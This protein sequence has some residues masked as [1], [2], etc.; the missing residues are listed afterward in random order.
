MIDGAEERIRCGMSETFKKVPTVLKGV[1]QVYPNVS[2]DTPIYAN[3]VIAGDFVFISGQTANNNETGNC[4]ASTMREQMW[5]VMEKI[6]RILQEA[7]SSLEFMVKD[8]IL[9]KDMKDYPVMRA[10]QQD[11][12]RQHAP[13]LLESP[14]GSTVCQ[15]AS[16]ARHHYLIEVEAVGYIPK[17]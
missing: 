12:F 11:Y 15:V 10:T 16:L 9:L 1:P 13:K 6:D 2:K 17:K 8:F 3:Y 14:P 5:I 7:G 4:T